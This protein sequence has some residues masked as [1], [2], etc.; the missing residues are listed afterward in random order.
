MKKNIIIITVV[1]TVIASIGFVLAKQQKKIE[2]QKVIVDRSN[3]SVAVSV[4]K[5]LLK[6]VDGSLQLPAT[7][8]PS[9][10]LI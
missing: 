10:R 2:K 5:V 7:L 1:A 8:A 4:E 3:I 6:T 9:K